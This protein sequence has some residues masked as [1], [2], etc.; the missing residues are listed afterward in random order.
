MV[1]STI[2]IP[3]III[4]KS[5]YHSYSQ[6]AFTVALS[7]RELPCWMDGVSSPPQYLKQ[8]KG[9]HDQDGD[10]IIVTVEDTR[11]KSSVLKSLL[12]DAAK[13]AVKF[14]E[15][16]VTFLSGYLDSPVDLNIET[17]ER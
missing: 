2:I 5:D 12:F 13:Q 17:I 4:L 11:G 14:T 8:L 9:S 15:K 3:I 10:M 16:Y 1:L 7:N 6:K